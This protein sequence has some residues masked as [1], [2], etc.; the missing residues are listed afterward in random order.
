MGVLKVTLIK[1]TN[2]AVRDVKSSDP[3]IALTIGQQVSSSSNL[4]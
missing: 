1:G 2:L 3:F 4:L